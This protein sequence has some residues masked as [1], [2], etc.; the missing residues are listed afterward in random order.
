MNIIIGGLTRR[1]LSCSALAASLVTA[2]AEETPGR[3]GD[4]VITATRTPTPL[5]D[6]GSA[7]TVIDRAQII[8][9][10]ARTLSDVL[11]RVPGVS[12]VQSGKPG[13]QTSIFL[14]G[15]N[16][17]QTLFLIDGARINNPLSGL[18]TLSSFTPDQIERIEVVRGPQSTLYGA[19]ALGGVI[20]IIT[21]QGEGP[22]TGSLTGEVGSDDAY[23]VAGEI[24]GGSRKFSGALSIAQWSTD[25]VAPNEDY[26]NFT[27]GGSATYRPLENF[28]LGAVVRFTK[29]ESGLPGPVAA[30]PPDLSERLEDQTLFARVSL[31]LTLFDIW[32]QTLSISET[33]EELFDRGDPFAVSDSRSDVLQVGWQHTVQLAKWNTL[34]AG[35]DWYLNRGEYE[36]LGATPFDESI[37][38]TAVYLQ[39]QA[40][41]F[42]RLSLTLG[43]RY[44]EHSEFGGHFTWRSAAVLRFD[45]PGTRLKASGG[46]GFKAPTLSDLFLTFP[47]PPP[48][49][50][51]VA[52]P[53]LEPEKSSGWDAGFE[54]DFGKWATLDVRYFENSVRDLITFAF[55]APNFTQT[56]IERART[57]GIEASLEVRPC[58]DLTL[59]AS[60]TWLAEAENLSTKGRLLRRPEH[61]AT[62]GAHYRLQ[63]RFDFHTQVTLVGE[64]ED[65]DPVTFARTDNG[66]YAKW[67][68]AVSA[69]VT[70]NV[71]VFGR[72]ENILD[73]DY[74]EA[75]G[76]PA[77]GRVFW[78]GLTLKF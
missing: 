23:R 21:R 42:D 20:N 1:V 69:E 41:F 33:H 60:Y 52:N 58:Q 49:S 57:R 5:D 6:V 34:T 31:D 22:M 16:S 44:D 75:L 3:L 36:T 10:Q 39:D 32:H 65:I 63:D 27:I 54:Q 53:D 28:A 45:E 2:T 18:V 50:S 51:F 35:L 19:D 43:G 73:E 62:V 30:V 74:E 8:A 78:G 7:V 29:A 13:G 24:S 14:R 48:F 68:V 55:V 66:R 47:S 46:T 40:T 59:W 15:L 77:L 37:T 56:N 38:N 17:N 71:R 67:D 76:F 64:R 12:V 72:V 26:E 70:S 4:T 25:N 11:R 9:S 61:T